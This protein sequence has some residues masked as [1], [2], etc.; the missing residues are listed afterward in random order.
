MTAL[1]LLSRPSPPHFFCLFPS[2]EN[3]E[4][5]SLAGS[6]RMSGLWKNLTWITMGCQLPSLRKSQK[7]LSSGTFIIYTPLSLDF[8][9]EWHKVNSASEETNGWLK[10]ISR[11][12]ALILLLPAHHGCYLSVHYQGNWG[13]SLAPDPGLLQR[14]S[15]GGLCGYRRNVFLPGL[16]THQGPGSHCPRGA[17]FKQER[18]DSLM[19]S[20]AAQIPTQFTVV[21]VIKFIMNVSLFYS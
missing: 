12:N 2:V 13:L 16:Q 18:A 21:G 15:R 7:Y 4:I 17:L 20:F 5:H 11:L 8:S 6:L 19:G 14:P 10:G 1:N 3:A 9:E